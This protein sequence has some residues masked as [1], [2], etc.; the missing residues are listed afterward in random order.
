MRLSIELD[1]NYVVFHNFLQMR[2]VFLYL[3]SII[4]VIVK[5]KYGAESEI[6]K[7]STRAIDFMKK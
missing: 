1:R 3:C 6:M 4:L 2:F 7:D 5:T